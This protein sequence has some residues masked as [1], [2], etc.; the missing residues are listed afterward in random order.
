MKIK[1]P[2]SIFKKSLF[3]PCQN[4]SLLPSLIPILKV[5]VR[6]KHLRIK[7]LENV[8][9]D[10]ERVFN[11]KKKLKQN[12]NH[13]S[14]FSQ[15]KRFLGDIYKKNP[16]RKIGYVILLT[17]SINQN[18][19]PIFLGFGLKSYHSFRN[20]GSYRYRSVSS[21]KNIVKTK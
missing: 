16:S 1:L 7:I 11:T 4:R 13:N 9:F 6:R 14:Q 8:S 19:C 2:R 21:F 12:L 10:F 5:L 3:S 17:L 18:L 20:Y 15:L